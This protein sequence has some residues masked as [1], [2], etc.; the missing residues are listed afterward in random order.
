[1]NI[2]VYCSS[3]ENLEQKYIDQARR[4]G[5][6]IGTRRHTLVYGGVNA[7]LMHVTAEA[8]HQSGGYLLGVNTHKFSS[9]SEPLVD[10]MLY[11]DD[12]GTRKALMYDHGDAF[13]VMPGGL[14]TIDEWISTLSQLI[15]DGDRSR[16]IF[17]L[18]DSGMYDHIIDQIH[19]TAGS[20]FS[21]DPNIECSVVV[22]GID[23][24]LEALTQFEQEYEK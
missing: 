12:L 5:Q 14:G 13:V 16:R 24:L 15:V 3:R 21:R 1:M 6:W 17:V 8:A 20:P 11:V 4:L 7:G 19:L 23:S 9:R 18:N 10:E 2:V 22:G